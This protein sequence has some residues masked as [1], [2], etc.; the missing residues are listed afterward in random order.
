MTQVDWSA[1]KKVADD[2]TKLIPDGEQPVE[3]TKAEA[4]T[5]SNGNPMIKVNLKVVDGPFTGRS[6]F[7]Q[8]T[9]SDSGFALGKFFEAL[10]A[11]GVNDQVL[12]AGPTLA[13][14]AAAIV[15]RRG[16]A[17]VDHSVYQGSERNGVKKIVRDATVIQGAVAI[18]APLGEGVPAVA[19]SGVPSS[20]P[21]SGP[22]TGVS[23][24]VGDGPPPPS[25]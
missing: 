11:L 8:L 19:P 10:D 12:A 18:A 2:A 9:V 16:T 14:I 7:T 6:L 1:L 17:V 24:V 23:P 3:V 15:G 21:S 5:S 4:T 13:Q 20:M 25:F 22:A